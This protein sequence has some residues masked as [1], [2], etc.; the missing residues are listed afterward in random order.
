MNHGGRK[1]KNTDDRESFL[2]T[3]EVMKGVDWNPEISEGL[4][5]DPSGAHGKSVGPKAVRTC[6]CVQERGEQGTGERTEG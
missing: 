5:S 4:K 1:Q 3:V 2:R 6:T